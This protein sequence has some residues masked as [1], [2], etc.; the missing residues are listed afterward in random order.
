MSEINIEI[1]ISTAKMLL[2]NQKAVRWIKNGQKGITEKAF[3]EEYLDHVDQVG[4]CAMGEANRLGHSLWVKYKGTVCFFETNQ[5]KVSEL[6]LSMG[7][8]LPH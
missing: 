5:D 4:F 1:E 3:V 6:S 8:E 7:I 2:P